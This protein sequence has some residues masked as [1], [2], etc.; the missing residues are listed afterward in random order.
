MSDRRPLDLLSKRVRAVRPHRAAV[1]RL[2]LGVRDGRFAR[3]APEIPPAEA[4]TVFDAD[5]LLGFPGVVDAHTHVGID[6]PL[7]EDARTESRAAASGGVTTMLTYFR[8]G[9]YDLTR[10]Q[11][12]GP[13]AGRL[14]RRPAPA[15]RGERP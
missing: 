6:A 12:L 9:Q 3:V 8:S 7:A 13:P 5:H 14:L 1:E 2:D 11:I 4:A 15:P 10:G